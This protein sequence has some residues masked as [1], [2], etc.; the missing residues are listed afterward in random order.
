MKK[1]YEILDKLLEEKKLNLNQLSLCIK[2][3]SDIYNSS[4]TLTKNYMGRE[5]ARLA[6]LFYFYPI[7]VFKY[8]QI[9]SYHN[10]VFKDG[11]RFFDIG[12]GPLTF[13]TALALLKKDVGALYAIDL[14]QDILNVGLK[15]L[16]EIEGEYEDKLKLT[17][18]LDDVDVLNFANVLNEL[19]EDEMMCLLKKYK[20]IKKQDVKVILFLEPAT[21]NSFY[22]LQRIGDYLKEQ[23]Y[24]KIN[25]CPLKSCPLPD[26]EWCH[27][28]IYFPR[29]KLIEAVE[30]KTGLNNK[31]VNY[32]YLLMSREDKEDFSFTS[33]D[34]RMI[35]NLIEHKGYYMAHFCSIKGVIIFELQ[36]R[37]ISES[38]KDFTL[39]KRGDIVKI[40]NVVKIGQRYRLTSDTFVK[41]GKKFMNINL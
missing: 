12:A 13:Y 39:L 11:M 8:L 14:N 29:S 37:D 38:N 41:M 34:Y 5:K 9:L 19:S 1:L 23:G 24:L 28:N 6:Y 21:K 26:K 31:F 10:S 4:N 30:N 7:N 36:K 16:K 15:I 2:E 20:N 27:E 22:R 32:C 33:N 18:P 17:V 25:H 40:E 35:S 3:L